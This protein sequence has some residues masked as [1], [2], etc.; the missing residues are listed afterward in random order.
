[1]SGKTLQGRPFASGSL[2]ETSG[3]LKE[4]EVKPVK[5]PQETGLKE[6]EGSREAS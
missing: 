4:K 1:M 6:K 3:N 5:K 2:K